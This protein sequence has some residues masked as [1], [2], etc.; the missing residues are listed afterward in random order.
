[1]ENAGIREISRLHHFFNQFFGAFVHDQYRAEIVLDIMTPEEIDEYQLRNPRGYA[2]LTH[3]LVE[4]DDGSI[5]LVP[6]IAFDP[7]I[8]QIAYRTQFTGDEVYATLA[9]MFTHLL[10][11]QFPIFF[12]ETLQYLQTLYQQKAD[13]EER[14]VFR[15]MFRDS[16]GQEIFPVVAREIAYL[17][18]K[19]NLP[20]DPQ[21]SNRFDRERITQQIQLITTLANEYPKVWDAYSMMF[22]RKR[23]LPEDDGGQ[24]MQ[25]DPKLFTNTNLFQRKRLP[26]DPETYLE[27]KGINESDYQHLEHEFLDAIF[28]PIREFQKA[29]PNFD[30]PPNNAKER[31]RRIQHLGKIAI[32]H[33]MKLREI[34]WK[35]YNSKVLNDPKNP[36][37]YIEEGK[38]RAA[39]VE[40][41]GTYLYQYLLMTLQ[42]ATALDK[43]RLEFVTTQYQD[44]NRLFNDAQQVINRW[45][46]SH[47]N[48]PTIR[49][50]PKEIESNWDMGY[51]E[52]N[53][54]IYI[55]LSDIRLY[56]NNQTASNYQNLLS[57]LIH[58]SIHH[59][60]ENNPQLALAM[61]QLYQ[62]RTK[63]QSPRLLNTFKGYEDSPDDVKVIPD[64]FPDI[65]MGV[66]PVDEK[67]TEILT[68]AIEHFYIFTFWNH[69]IFWYTFNRDN[70]GLLRILKLNLENMPEKILAE[71]DIAEA[72]EKYYYQSPVSKD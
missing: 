50:L 19:S 5:A 58:E 7:Q 42:P 48:F 35:Y 39:L 38:I 61:Y 32:D 11:E 33:R 15:Q 64:R 68:T 18:A 60:L 43:P 57:I 20:I 63:G 59:L 54:A 37:R 30:Q 4:K 71:K 36:Q 62:R 40:T 49:V 67:H 52:P 46:P 17:I 29:H 8:F 13:Q 10:Q 31:L 56:Q 22:L 70:D 47:L 65:Y 2:I 27:Q 72:I 55:N 51:Y 9:Y 53:E 25:F 44:V 16:M 34:L 26:K 3:S 28:N 41:L 12:T 6:R 14:H 21:L 69:P 1:M 45:I 66:V 23:I 24:P